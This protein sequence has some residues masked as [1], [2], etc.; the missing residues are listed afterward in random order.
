MAS[1]AR[2]YNRVPDNLQ[3]RNQDRFQIISA[4]KTLRAKPPKEVL[5][6]LMS[7]FSIGG[8]QARKLFLKGWVIKDQL[9]AGEVV[10]FRTQLQQLGLKIEVHPAGTFDNRAILARLKFARQ[11][12]E[13]KSQPA[14]TTGR[15]GP[16]VAP[17]LKVATP[18]QV[19]SS[20]NPAPSNPKPSGGGVPSQSTAPAAAKS[21]ATQRSTAA[22]GRGAK[23]AP[24]LTSPR[25]SEPKDSAARAQLRALFRSAVSAASPAPG[26]RIA[27]LPQLLL[28]SVVPAGFVGLLLLCLY[29]LGGAFWALPS[30]VLAGEFGVG[31][32]A[33]SGVTILLVCF[34]MALIL[35]PFFSNGSSGLHAGVAGD[36]DPVRLSK[37]DA[38]GLF[39][40]L[41]VMAET[42]GVSIARKQKGPRNLAPANRILTTEVVVTAG[43]EIRVMQAPFS[44]PKLSLGLG[45]VST[46]EG[47]DVVALMARAMS[48]YQN[49]WYRAAQ[50]LAIGTSERLQRAQDAL[51]RQATIIGADD[52]VPIVLKPLHK[53]LV[54]CGRPLAPL[55]DRLQA[56]HRHMSGPLARR[57][58]AHADLAAGQLVGSDGFHHFAERWNRLVHADLVCGEI[59]REAQLLGKRLMNVPLAVRWLYNNTSAQTLKGIDAAMAEETDC[60]AQEEPAGHLR[61]GA[62]EEHQLPPGLQR[63]DFSLQKL[64]IDFTELATRVSRVGGD[65]SCRPVENRLLLETDKNAEAAQQVLTRYFNRAIPRDFVHLQLPRNEELRTLDLQSCIDWLRGR[66]VDLQELEQRIAQLQR[67]GARIQIGA[68]LVRA[69]VRVDPRLYDLNGTTPAA[70]DES[71][72]DNRVRL[73]ECLQQRQQLHSMFYLRVERAMATMVAADRKAAQTA[74]ARLRKFDALNEPLTTLN[75]YS[76]VVC[77]LIERAPT[78]EL[79]TA[80]LQKYPQLIAQQIRQ[81]E[82]TART[83]QVPLTPA[84]LEKLQSCATGETAISGAARGDDVSGALQALELRGKSASGVVMEAYQ[85]ELAQLL[86]LCLAEEERLKVKPLRLAS[87]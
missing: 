60:W 72:Q 27:M 5:Q 17:A 25:K 3:G 12:Q 80:L 65:D 18:S 62:V 52:T 15:P 37:R 84:Q 30:A 63:Q 75:R 48:P 66:L 68:A 82:D 36:L 8:D 55:F 1:Q 53:L 85:A 22:Q 64:F 42:C 71:R 4:G 19:A 47:G 24:E 13:R 73:S 39:L 7:A 54:I 9:T 21:A 87:L 35:T 29:Q 34:C 70:T 57:L 56:A 43:A 16:E 20:S 45:A 81:L 46:L 14:T 28:A 61:I 49:H 40:L 44:P 26:S 74:L 86:A 59:N 50:S 69:N 79:P 58:E 32:L 10:Q 2:I 33:G 41:E 51:E 78:Q 83:R 67:K 23:N 31:T 76:D 77:E 11:R 38:P 6:Q